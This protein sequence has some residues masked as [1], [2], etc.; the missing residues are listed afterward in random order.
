MGVTVLI[1][2]LFQVKCYLAAILKRYCCH[3]NVTYKFIL[4]TIR[5][6]TC[7]SIQI[8]LLNC[9]KE[10]LLFMY[11]ISTMYFSILLKVQGATLWPTRPNGI[12][13]KISIPNSLNCLNASESLKKWKSISV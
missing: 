2:K 13:A 7:S 6:L 4:T 12:F 5:L 8:N 9:Y 11:F 3:S 10:Q 1:Y